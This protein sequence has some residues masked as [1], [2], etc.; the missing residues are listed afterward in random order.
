MKIMG[1]Y[2]C[3]DTNICTYDTDNDCLVYFKL[4]RESGIKHHHVCKQPTNSIDYQKT[5]LNFIKKKCDEWN[6]YPDVIVFSD[7][8]KSKLGGCEPNNFYEKIDNKIFLNHGICKKNCEVFCIDHHYAHVLSCWPVKRT[9]EVDIGVSLDNG[10]DNGWTGRI[11]ATPIK[12]K[13]IY[14]ETRKSV[15]I[16]LTGIGRQAMGLKG[17]GLDIAG[18]V[19]G[20]QSYGTIQDTKNFNKNWLFQDL[21]E[22]WKKSQPKNCSFGNS[23]FNNWLSTIHHLGEEFILDLFEKYCCVK[24]TITYSGGLAQ[25]TVYNESLHKKYNIHIIP[26]C[27]DGGISIGCIELARILFNLKP[28]SNAGFPYWQSDEC[29][30]EPSEETIKLIA[31]KIADGKIVGWFQGKGELG[32]RALGNRSILMDPRNPNGKNIINKKV[33]HREWW[34]PYAPSVLEECVSEWFETNDLSPYMLRATKVVSGKEKII[35]A[36][37]HVDNTS[38]FQSV[39]YKQNK[40]FYNLI[41]EF[42]KITDVPMILNTSLNSGGSPIFSKKKQCLNLLKNTDLDILCYGNKIYD[43]NLRL[44]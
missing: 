20:A 29:I 39:N 26:H 1:F 44:L 25:N 13:L 3:H 43:S 15:G 5:T 18:K 40:V 24:N 16:M 21:S 9:E 42:F 37:T 11:I 7:G 33:K 19:M 27:Y 41:K 35:P 31:K 2:C 36:V 14:N 23:Q 17:V 34:R 6:F 12:P 10:G 38:R 22:N 30:E 8:W 4:E 28:F 32:P